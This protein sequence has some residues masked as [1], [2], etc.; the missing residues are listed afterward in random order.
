MRKLISLFLMTALSVVPATPASARS[1]EETEILN[2][3]MEKFRWKTTGN[4]DAVADLFDDELV[5]VHLNG[6]I[7]SKSEWIAQMRSHRFVYKAIE[8]EEIPSV[9]VY[10]GT[11]VLVG[12]AK[13]KV[14]MSGFPGSYK[15]VYTEVYVKKNNKWK[16]VNLHTC[17]Y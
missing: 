12:K 6:N 13:F 4:V 8:V 14:S 1:A 7:T 11:A 10:D 16:L 15:L 3:S 9:K 17:S 2:L 5:F